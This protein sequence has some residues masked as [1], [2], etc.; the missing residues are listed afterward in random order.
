VPIR[1]QDPV[2]AAFE[3]ARQGRVFLADVADA[4]DG[5]TQQYSKEVLG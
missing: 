2:K 5:D 1:D 3:F 4:T